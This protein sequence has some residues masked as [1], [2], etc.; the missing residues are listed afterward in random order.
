LLKENRENKK[1]KGD[2]ILRLLKSNKKKERKNKYVK[3]HF[4]KSG[5]LGFLGKGIVWS[6]L[7]RFCALEH[8]LKYLTIKGWVS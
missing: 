6:V 5:E 8:E 3:M 2:G 1:K 7:C 4:L